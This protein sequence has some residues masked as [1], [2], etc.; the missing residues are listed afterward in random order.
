MVARVSNGVRSS[1]KA[2][3][4]DGAVNHAT[5]GALAPNRPDTPPL[6]SAPPTRGAAV[7]AKRC[8]RPRGFVVSCEDSAPLSCDAV[9]GFREAMN[10]AFDPRARALQRL[11]LVGPTAETADW[12]DAW[13]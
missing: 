5:D 3:E 7:P 11:A 6:P 4:A 10:A 9:R 12:L 13:A 2:D 8:E 1:L